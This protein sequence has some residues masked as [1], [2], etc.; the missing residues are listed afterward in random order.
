MCVNWNVGT[1]LTWTGP[2]STARLFSTKEPLKACRD[3][4]SPSRICP[5]RFDIKNIVFTTF[6]TVISLTLISGPVTA[7]TIEHDKNLEP[8]T[9]FL[10]F[11]A[12]ADPQFNKRI[13]HPIVAFQ[14]DIAGFLLNKL[15][16]DKNYKGLIIAGDLT[17]R[18]YKWEILKLYNSLLAD[19]ENTLSPILEHSKELDRLYEGLGNHD[20][21][22]GTCC[23]G[24][25]VGENCICEGNLTNIIGRDDRQD[26]TGSQPPHYSWEWNGIR[27]I[28]LNLL[29][30][31]EPETVWNGASRD[32]QDALQFLKDELEDAGPDKN[33]IVVHHYGMDRFSNKWWS[34]ETKNAYAKAIKD[35]RV[36]AMITGHLH[37]TRR[38]SFM[39]QC[40]NG[41]TAVTVGSIRLGFHLDFKIVDDHL[42][43]SRMRNGSER[44]SDSYSIAQG[45][46]QFCGDN[47]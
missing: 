24:E 42:T 35:Y 7:N 37:W 1:H 38:A 31:D 45:N 41:L 17:E 23:G 12:A 36:V 8:V 33:V 11:A 46:T 34:S 2:N 20:M 32:P 29:P 47:T 5:M 30:A 6:L 3:D 44:W 43:V 4:V 39:Q 14:N 16:N 21:M 18:T 27:F 19:E 15:Y 28:Q 13:N 22:K 10:S 40:W 9:D 26:Q 25:G